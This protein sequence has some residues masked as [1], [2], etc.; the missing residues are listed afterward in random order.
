MHH[1]YLTPY[2]IVHIQQPHISHG[3]AII[4]SVVAV[5]VLCVECL[6]IHFVINISKRL[7]DSV[8]ETLSPIEE[9]VKG[10]ERRESYKKCKGFPTTRCWEVQRT[11]RLSITVG[12]DCK[13]LALQHASCIPHSILLCPHSAAT[14]LPWY[15]HYTLP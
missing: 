1:V 5:V 14:H 6:Y 4:P 15:C 9:K 3:V 13:L 12:N 2:S 11:N 8:S 7:L 10:E